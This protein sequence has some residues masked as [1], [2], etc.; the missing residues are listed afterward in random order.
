MKALVSIISFLAF[1]ELRV[2]KRERERERKDD[3]EMAHMKMMMW[4][5][6]LLHV[7]TF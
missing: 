4:S 5:R 1:L 6:K 3:G 7:G 2:R